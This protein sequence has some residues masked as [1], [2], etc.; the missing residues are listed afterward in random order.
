MCSYNVL[1]QLQKVERKCWCYL[2]SPHQQSHQ[3]ANELSFKSGLATSLNVLEDVS[4]LCRAIWWALMDDVTAVLQ[5]DQ[6]SASTRHLELHAD[7]W[8]SVLC[9]VSTNGMNPNDPTALSLCRGGHT[10]T[11][12]SHL[13]SCCPNALFLEPTSYRMGCSIR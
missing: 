11:L 12:C 6:C 10:Q 9:I 1:L 8:D 2:V 7:P 13:L 4:I 5:V 3:L